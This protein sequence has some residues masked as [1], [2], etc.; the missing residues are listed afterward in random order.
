MSPTSSWLAAVVAG[1]SARNA[2]VIRD[3][4]SANYLDACKN[5]ASY[6][7]TTYEVPFTQFIEFEVSDAKVVSETKADL[8]GVVKGTVSFH[9]AA[10]DSTTTIQLDVARD[11]Y[12]RE[13]SGGWKEIGNQSCP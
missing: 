1:Y 12:L 7:H 3:V 9:L 2:E 8:S 5:K 11:V 10:V 6:M 13:E 4:V